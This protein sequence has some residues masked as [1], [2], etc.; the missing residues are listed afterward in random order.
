MLGLKDHKR[1]VVPL[2][3]IIFVMSGVVFPNAEYEV[4][5]ASLVWVPYIVTYGLIVPVVLLLVFWIKKCVLKVGG[6]K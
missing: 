1:I 6:I 3:L 2:G 5:W 4:N